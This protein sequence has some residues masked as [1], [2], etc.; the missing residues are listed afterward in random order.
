MMSTVVK[1]N[2]MDHNKLASHHRPP[3]KMNNAT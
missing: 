2:N 3:E 1:N